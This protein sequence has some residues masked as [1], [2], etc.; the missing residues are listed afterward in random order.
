MQRGRAKVSIIRKE[1][2]LV[3]LLL[4]IA[5]IF[6]SAVSASAAD[7]GLIEAATLKNAPSGWV[8]LDARPKGEWEAG[9]IPGAR[10]LSWETYTRTDEKGIPYQP[11]PLPAL[12]TALAA[13]G[14]DEKTP[15]VVYGDA[16]TSWGGEGWTAW[17]L[18]WLGHQG[19][20]RLL[21]GGIQSWRGAN[22]PLVRGAEP[23]KA[24]ARYRIEL[25]PQHD[26]STAEV[27]S[28]RATL[29]LIDTRSTLEWLKGRIP[30]AIHIPWDEFYQGETRAPLSPA[31]FKE[32]LAEN[33]VDMSK[34]IVY[35]CAG[36][37]RSAYVWLIHELSGLP[38][39]RNYE[40]SMEAWKRREGN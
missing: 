15:V 13:M 21:N 25:Q 30:G 3:G 19:P 23:V 28:G 4:T 29:T 38:H 12:A 5:I 32:L 18:A 8:V 40:G 1:S 34:P 20:I 35:Y 17:L 10:S 24:V 9:H 39:A 22:L 14:I 37:I 7:L 11:L 27:A 6:S 2:L 31:Q 33:Q 16:D 36:G 26:I